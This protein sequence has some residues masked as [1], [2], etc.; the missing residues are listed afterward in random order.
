MK[1][2]INFKIYL[3]IF[4]LILLKPNYSQVDLVF[5]KYNIYVS[6]YG[7]VSIYSVPDNVRQLYRAALLVGTGFDSV[8]DLTFDKD[9]ED[10]TQLLSV[11]SFGDY[12]I[13]GSYNNNYSGAPPNVLEKENI[14]CWQSIGAFIIKYTVINRELN[15]INAIIGLE[16]LPRI[17][18]NRAGGD[19]VT[20]SNQTKIISVKNGRSVGFKALSEDLKSVGMFYYFTDYESDSLFYQWLSYSSYDS[21]FITNP[22]DPNVDAPAI[23]PA[24][25]QRTINPNDSAIIYVAIAYGEQESEMLAALANAQ[26]LYDTLTS[27]D[28][29]ENQILSDFYLNQNY[30]NPFNPNTIISWNVPFNSYQ[31]L[32]VYD[33]LGNE[34]ASLVNEYRTAGSYAINFNASNLSSGV[35]YYKLTAG[36]FTETKKMILMR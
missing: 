22:A 11:P 36:N 24:F 5:D 10:S 20:F 33:V 16:F 17:N 29:N 19:T 25:N 1:T 9:I 15:P 13:Y 30:P 6:T 26:Q 28:N 4:I 18:N 21:L 2:K 8:F 12:E 31:T 7:R 23:I 35:Y 34:V 14:Y 27:V 3:L 32:K